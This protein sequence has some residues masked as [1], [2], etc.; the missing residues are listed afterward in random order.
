MRR[1]AKRC[2]NIATVG[3]ISAAAILVMGPQA[4]AAAKIT[5]FCTQPFAPEGMGCFYSDGD[6]VRVADITRDGLR[7]VAE[8]RVGGTNEYRECHDSNGADNGY[9]WCNFNVTENRAMSIQIVAR[10]GANGPNKM[11]GVIVFGN[12]SGR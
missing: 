4:H 10:N 5:E 2:L 1:T 11:Q 12:T 7:A 9:T 6:R 3:A 8:I